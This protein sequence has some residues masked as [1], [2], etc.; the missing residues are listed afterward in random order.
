[1][2][3]WRGFIFGLSIAILLA[4]SSP[5]R[6]SDNY[7]ETNHSASLVVDFQTALG[8]LD[9]TNT[10]AHSISL[11][12]ILVSDYAL[13]AQKNTSNIHH[14]DKS[15][16]DHFPNKTPAYQVRI[17][18][19]ISLP[20]YEH[21]PA[22]TFGAAVQIE[23]IFLLAYEFQPEILGIKHFLAPL[24]TN[25]AVPWYLRANAANNHGRTAGWKDGNT[26]YTGTITYLS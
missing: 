19:N 26:L 8:D 13:L 20:P 22:S 18:P 3:D 7:P 23:P 10:F 2:W 12:P 11:A 6:A 14:D 4:I 25:S 24:T 16:D 5:A 9:N 17:N 15:S 1:M 21:Q